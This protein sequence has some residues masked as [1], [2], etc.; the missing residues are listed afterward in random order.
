MDRCF[1]FLIN[2]DQCLNM[3]NFDMF[4]YKMENQQ[5]FYLNNVTFF[6]ESSRKDSLRSVVEDIRMYLDKYPFRVGDYQITLAM[7]Q[8]FQKERTWETSLLY[9]ILRIIYELRRAHIFIGSK[10]S[11]EKTVNII[12]LYD[13]DFRAEAVN[14]ENYWE[15]SFETEYQLLLDYLRVPRDSIDSEED[16]RACLSEI[17]DTFGK[18]RVE[19]DSIIYLLKCFLYRFSN[20]DADFQT[21]GWE[22]DE[23]DLNFEQLYEENEDDRPVSSV[24]R[25]HSWL[26]KQYIKE[27]TAGMQIYERLI[28]RNNRRQMILSLLRIVEFITMDDDCPITQ[29]KDTRSLYNI[30]RS[31]WNKV[32]DDD[33]LEI[34]YSQMLWEYQSSLKIALHDIERPYST[35]GQKEKLPKYDPPREI[36]SSD[37]MHLGSKEDRMEELGNIL[38]GFLNRNGHGIVQQERWDSTYKELKNRLGHMEQDLRLFADDLGTQYRFVLEK[39][40]E[41]VRRWKSQKIY[42][43]KETGQ[44][45]IQIGMERERRLANLKSPHMNPSLTFQDQLN[46]ENALEQANLDIRFFISCQKMITGANFVLLLMI[47]AGL[48]L[49]QYTLFQYYVL[50]D[51][52]KLLAWIAYIGLVIAGMFLSWWMPFHYFRRKMHDA[53]KTLQNSME[54]YVAGYLKKEEDFREYLNEINQLDYVTRYLRILVGADEAAKEKARKYLW[55]RSQIEA[56]LSK[57]T[58]FQGLIDRHAGS[59]SDEP[60]R[61]FLQETGELEKDVVDCMLYWPQG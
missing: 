37:S 46:M 9:K 42:A 21:N 8:P 5:R 20:S 34:R 31:R 56:H 6:S 25:D 55:H 33:T 16:F 15:N 28:D 43:D 41:E 30:S 14:L 47:C 40:K 51:S 36:K 17:F 4:F 57:L 13:S 32:W 60:R 22:E 29:E 50:Q 27:R 35:Y 11:V 48:C 7:R 53:V 10:E 2:V 12:M 26:L 39:R 58:F 1:H 44:K 61:T 38:R 3:S 59:F 49:G 19:E 45:I 23:Y 24:S 52:E 54:L 18:T